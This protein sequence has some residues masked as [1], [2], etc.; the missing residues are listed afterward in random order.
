MVCYLSLLS[1]FHNTTQAHYLFS[2]CGIV[3]IVHTCPYNLFWCFEY[4]NVTLSGFFFP[5]ASGLCDLCFP[6]VVCFLGCPSVS[7]FGRLGVHIPCTC[8]SATVLSSCI[9]LFVIMWYSCLFLLVVRYMC[10]CWCPCTEPVH[11]HH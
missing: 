5:E 4:F 6:P 2:S 3:Y 7:N 11:G 10:L 1:L 9:G 8:W